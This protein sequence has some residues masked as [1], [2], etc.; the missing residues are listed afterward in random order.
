MVAGKRPPFLDDVLAALLLIR[1]LESFR[2]FFSLA[3]PGANA[4]SGKLREL[5]AELGNREILQRRRGL[6]REVERR[7]MD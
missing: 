2:G 5:C 1:V 6:I 4:A 3:A 7:N